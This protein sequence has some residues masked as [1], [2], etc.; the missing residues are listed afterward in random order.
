[1]GRVQ[2][3]AMTVKIVN[4]SSLLVRFLYPLYEGRGGGLVVKSVMKKKEPSCHTDFFKL[5]CGKKGSI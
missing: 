5:G 3:L 1:L 2:Q 4:G